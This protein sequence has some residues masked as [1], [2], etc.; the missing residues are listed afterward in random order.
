[1]GGGVPL[2][3][4]L[5]GLGLE[6]D[7]DARQELA[8]GLLGAHHDRVRRR[9]ASDQAAAFDPADG[10]GDGGGDGNDGRAFDGVATL[11]RSAFG[12]AAGG[13]GCLSPK[14][15]QDLAVQS[16]KIPPRPSGAVLNSRFIATLRVSA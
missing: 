10:V 11:E 1:G 3:G 14:K 6:L 2:D 5:R 12:S 13:E 15:S 4:V 9:G 8:D 7:A 16:Q